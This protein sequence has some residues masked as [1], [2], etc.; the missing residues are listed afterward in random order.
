MS[1]P[2]LEAPVRLQDGRWAVGAKIFETNAQAWRYID[3]ISHEPVSRSEDVG[4]WVF[5][6]IANRE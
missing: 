6:K 4:D 3:R 5:N 2:N 1:A